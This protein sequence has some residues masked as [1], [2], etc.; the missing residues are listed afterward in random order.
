[1]QEIA[2]GIY[3]ET[4]FRR[5]NV[6]AILTRDGFVLID[7]PPYPDDAR[8]WRAR[9]AGISDKPVL[10]IVNTDCHRDRVLGNCWFDARVIVAH[11]DTVI[12]MRNLP[13]AY[14][15][16]AVEALTADRVERAAFAGVHLQM[17]SVGFTRRIQLRYGGWEIP[18]LAMAGP[19][20]GSVWVHLPEQ[21][22]L[23]ASDSIIVDQHPYIA[24]AY[25]KAWLENLTSLRRTRFAADI[26]VP[27]RGPLVDKDATEPISNYLRLARRRVYSLFRAGRPRADTVTLV[28]ELL[29]MF[30][31]HEQDLERIQRRIKAGLDRIYDE[32][33]TNDKGPD[34]LGR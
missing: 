31:Y 29:E 16:S 15:E 25:T 5:V 7:T 30:P 34:F 19:T 28:P 9:L 14:L 27:G 11:D 2:P 8:Q 1:V 23:F 4:D 6:G 26:I 13:S 12:Q 17:P 32:F 3:V 24:S 33:R 10:A 22:I 18:L 20:A 21:R